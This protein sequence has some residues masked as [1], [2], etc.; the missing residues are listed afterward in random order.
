MLL[1]TPVEKAPTGLISRTDGLHGA[2]RSFLLWFALTV[3]HLGRTDRQNTTLIPGI[4]ALTGSEQTFV[5]HRC[6][7]VTSR[8]YGGDHAHPRGA[9]LSQKKTPLS[10]Y[11]RR[12]KLK[13][14]EYSYT[15]LGR[16]HPYPLYLIECLA[17]LSFTV[18]DDA[19]LARPLQSTIWTAGF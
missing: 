18:E 7:A 3:A 11:L 19:V 5:S 16:V 6:C 10:I 14:T 15:P 1:T 17:C 4:P 9:P 2:S 13:A 8:R 12:Q